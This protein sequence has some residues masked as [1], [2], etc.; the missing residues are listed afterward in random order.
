M[1]R[2]TRDFTL[3]FTSWQVGVRKPVIAAVNG[4][5]AGG[6][7]HF[8]ADADIV[9]ASSTATFTDPHVSVGQVSAFE[10]IAL[11]RMSPMEPVL[12]MAFTGRHERMT[13]AR[14]HQL[15][16][17]SEVVDP[18]ERLRD[19]AAELAGKIAR[20]SPTAMAVTKQALWQ[21]LERDLTDACRVGARDL[22]LMWGHPDQEEGPAAFAEKRDPAWTPLALPE[23]AP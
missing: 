10:T 17:L 13:A 20:N 6:G 8:V 9:I 14:A 3:R 1:S 2:Q 12:R 21:A 7:L 11:T 19:A 15:G 4:I 16:I 18:P 23:D 22:A 5:C